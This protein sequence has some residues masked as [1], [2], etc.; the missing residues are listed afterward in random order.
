MRVLLLGGTGFI[1]TAVNRRLITAGHDTVAVG[2]GEGADVAINVTDNAALSRHL[3]DHGY[4]AVVN[5]LGAGLTPGTTDAAS[6]TAVNSALPPSLLAIL[7]GLGEA[8]HLV[9]AASS[10]ERLPGQTADESEYS[11]TKHEGTS[12]LHALAEVSPSP[13]T[14]VTIHNTYGPGQPAGRFVAYL[15]DRLGKGL[16]VELNFPHRIRDFVYLGDVAECVAYAVDAGPSGQRE[17]EVG[18]GIGTSLLDA[19]RIVASSMGQAPELVAATASL[20]ED[21]N[22]TTVATTLAGT[23]GLCTT[24]FTE[25]IRRTIVEV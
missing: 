13:V 14:I 8:P 2:R 19:A 6:M 22:P 24:A 4:D 1:G 11:R 15:I 5:L 9:H 23:Y 12:A 16:P 10:T 7:N 3:S 18:T 17:V 20:S 25:G 21:P